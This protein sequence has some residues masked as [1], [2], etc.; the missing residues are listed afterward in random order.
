M[1]AHAVTR[2]G[3]GADD[4]A[5]DGVPQEEVENAIQGLLKRRLLVAVGAPRRASSQFRPNVLPTS[6]QSQPRGMPDYCGA[7]P[8]GCGTS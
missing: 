5:P 4:P 3:I 7:R 2:T 1:Y 6:S 8:T